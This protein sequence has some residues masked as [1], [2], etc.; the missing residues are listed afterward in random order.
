[1]LVVSSAIRISTDI[2]ILS[3]MEATSI[4]PGSLANTVTPTATGGISRNGAIMANLF[5]KTMTFWACSPPKNT[6]FTRLRRLS[7]CS[8]AR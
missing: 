6:T 5:M 4:R 1:M 7:P 3:R 2:S 8:D